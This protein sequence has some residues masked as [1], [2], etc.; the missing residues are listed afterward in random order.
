MVIHGQDTASSRHYL[1]N[2]IFTTPVAKNTTI[3]GLA[4]GLVPVPWMNAD[5][6]KINGL[7]IDI[8][9]FGIIGGI[10]NI[11][12]TFIAPFGKDSSHRGANDIGSNKIF[13]EFEDSFSTEIKGVSLSMGGLPRQTKMDGLTINIVSSVANEMHGFEISGIMN[14]HY[15][16]RGV[17]IAGLRNKTT[18]GSGVQIALFN[19][20]RSGKVLQIGLINRI[21]KR[22]VPFINFSF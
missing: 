21:G 19:N 5:R 7:N 4:V 10:G 8:Q 17:M 22:V 11:I 6:L 3:N 9:P 20:C 12:G 16:F 15:A 2:I 1:R 14:L 13:P 18:T